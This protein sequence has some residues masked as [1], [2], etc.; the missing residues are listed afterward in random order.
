MK[1]PEILVKDLLE[2]DKN[3]SYINLRVAN[4]GT[5]AL[6]CT[7]NVSLST[8]GKGVQEQDTKVLSIEGTEEEVIG[9][10]KNLTG[11]KLIVK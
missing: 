5:G 3:G 11:L 4:T 7:V 8:Q 9:A 2:K 10:V 1:V 6:S